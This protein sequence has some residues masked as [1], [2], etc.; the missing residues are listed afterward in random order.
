ML[1]TVGHFLK[2]RLL[3]ALSRAIVV[4]LCVDLPAF[5]QITSDGT[6][7]TVVNTSGNT[8]IIT[9]GTQVG[10]NLFHSFRDFSLLSTSTNEAIFDNALG[11]QTIIT[12]VTGGSISNINGLIQTNGNANLFF[13]NPN[14]IIFGE[15]ATLRIGGSF[16]A[17]TASSLKFDDGREFSAIAS[18]SP[19]LLSIS[20]PTGL[21]YGSNPGSIQVQGPG[22]Y[23]YVNPS[24]FEIIRTLRPPGLAVEPGKTLALIGGS[25][26]VQ[27]GNL[28][29]EQGHIE[30]GAISNSTVSFTPTTSGWD[31]IYPTTASFQD[32]TFAQAASADVSGNGGGRIRVQGQQINLLDGSSLL[33]LTLGN[34]TAGEV[35]LNATEAVRIQ[36]ESSWF[37]S[38]LLTEVSLGATGQGGNITVN[39]GQV[40]AADGAKISTSTHG[41]GDGGQLTMNASAIEIQG[42][43]PNFGPTLLSADVVGAAG[44]GGQILINADQL[45]VTAGGGISA[46]TSGS[47]HGSSV[48]IQAKTVEFVGGSPTAGASGLFV[49]TFPGSTGQ[50]GDVSI[51]ADRFR[52]TEGAQVVLDT[53][54]AGNTGNFQLVA[55][56]LEIIGTSP[57]GDA[58]QLSMQVQSG[59]IGNGGVYQ[60]QAN[61]IEIADGGKIQAVTFGD[62]SA[63]RFSIAAQD[64][65]LTGIGSNILMQVAPGS[66]GNAGMLNI[67]TDRLFLAE[68]AQIGTSTSGLGNAGSLTIRAQD[69]E[70]RGASTPDPTGIFAAVSPGGTGQGADLLIEAQHLRILGGA[71]IAADTLGSGNAGTLTVKAQNVELSGVAS[72]G[73]SGLF[74]GAIVGTGSGGDIDI[75]SD[76]LVIRDGAT[77]SASNFP[78]R[79]SAIPA[80]RGAAGDIRIRSNL[81]SL[82]NGSIT[83]STVTGGKGNVELR[84]QT[85]TLN[86]NS[87]IATN[88]QGLEPGGNIQ[89]NTNFLVGYRNSDIT[90]NAVNARGG[91]VTVTADGIFGIAPRGRL[92]PES[93]ITATS[94]LGIEFNGIVQI[95]T[96][97]VDPSRGLDQLPDGLI[98]HQRIVA[99]CEPVRGSEF[100]ITGRGGLPEDASQTLRG[101]TVWEDLRVAQ[102]ATPKKASSLNSDNK[103][104]S[105]KSSVLEAHGWITNTNGKVELVATASEVESRANHSRNVQCAA[106][107]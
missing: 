41:D 33:A 20:T 42:E 107:L 77:I 60:L 61:R 81:I 92:T 66:Q 35:T 16:F 27:G 30:I 15:Q 82:N 53:Y 36:G 24:P 49:A 93:D 48:Q 3:Q 22:N 90:A 29:A 97:N 38:S 10:N 88:S 21:Q 104:P 101:G 105:G 39:A 64:V 47:G 83:A 13:L 99:S 103:L 44:N 32:V 80:G 23:L 12:R 9:G 102:S 98:N 74:A 63:G 68:G 69:I 7:G 86:N 5:A 84:S 43:S 67:A 78:S 4:L 71:Q 37:P 17:S 58:S 72:Q 14:G 89:I 75:T 52:L 2:P 106:Q 57:G 45:H 8:A 85:L 19:P 18:S 87:L 6:V 1:S 62:G 51:R 54:G 59:A 91:Q 95:N 56:V 100:I 70:L 65:A 31:F 11:I 34:G 76:R 46:S 25:V 73:R 28:T 94:E 96:P 50:G 55:D 40:L 79:N 26:D